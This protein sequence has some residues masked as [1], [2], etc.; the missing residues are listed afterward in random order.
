MNRYLLRYAFRVRQLSFT[1]YV[2]LYL[3]LFLLVGL[4]YSPVDY[5]K[6]DWI[7]TT[8]SNP[9][10]TFVLTCIVAPLV[11]SL[12]FLFAPNVNH[13]TPN[14]LKSKRTAGAPALVF[15]IITFS[16]SGHILN[17]IVMGI[18]LSLCYYG[19]YKQGKKAAYWAVTTV[20]ILRN[21]LVY[22]YILCTVNAQGFTNLSFIKYLL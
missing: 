11:L 17:S 9:L 18:V 22:L 10:L 13:S 3:V 7:E 14:S 15:A 8:S 21:L 4:P 20:L 5:L 16:T 2:M 6:G 1:P 19:Y 12:I